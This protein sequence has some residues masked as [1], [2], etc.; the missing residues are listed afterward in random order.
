MSSFHFSPR[1]ILLAAGVLALIAG[2]A[3][4]ELPVAALSVA[5]YR[6]DA[7]VAYTPQDR[8]IGLMN[9]RALAPQR[10]MVFIFP[11]AERH[12]MWM[13]NTLVP[14]SVAFAD[15]EGRIINVERMQP[16]TEDNHCAA[17]PARYALE[18]NLDWFE[19]KH[20]GPGMRINGLDRLPRGR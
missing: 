20:I 4:A 19:A 15:D 17:H 8:E 1:R 6:V 5:M 10:G 2:T 13:K 3:R 9:R 14:L 11:E 12:C 18:M 16:Q 7:E